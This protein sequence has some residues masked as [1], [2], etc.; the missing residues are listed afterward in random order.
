M[1]SP[2]STRLKF[3]LRLIFAIA[4]APIPI[5]VAAATDEGGSVSLRETFRDPINPTV[6]LRR[7]GARK[8]CGASRR[9][10]TP[11]TRAVTGVP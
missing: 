3:G 11:P 10:A 1:A 8:H 9:S 7:L 6:R 5:A 4:A 2:K